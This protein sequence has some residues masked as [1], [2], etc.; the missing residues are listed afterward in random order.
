MRIKA[1]IKTGPRDIK[2]NGKTKI[3]F[4]IKVKGKPPVLLGTDKEVLPDHWDVAA[5]LPNRK[6]PNQKLLR[7]WIN[8]EIEKIE[9]LILELENAGKVPTAE[10]VKQRYLVS[11]LTYVVT[12]AEHRLKLESHT[13]SPKSLE[14][15]KRS[16]KN[17]K[18]Y[19]PRLKFSELT[20]DFL[21]E[22]YYYLKNVKNHSVNSIAHDLRSLRKFTNAALEAGVTNHYPFRG[23]KI[24]TKEAA[25]EFNSPEEVEALEALFTSGSLPEPLQKTLGF[26]LFACFT[27]VPGDDLRKKEERLEFTLDAVRYE[28]GKTQRKGKLLVIP[29]IERARPLVS[30]IQTNKLK[31]SKSRVNND[32][33]DIMK[34]AGIDKNITFHC[35]RN[36]FYVIARRAGI[37][38]GAIQD[39]LGHSLPSTTN[40]Y[41][42]IENEYI[43]E[44][45]EKLNKKTG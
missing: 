34:R 43:R 39:I 5:G 4:S 18:E 19:V 28:R 13:L 38:E 37:A 21:E 2:A 36:T 12:F 16:I 26:Y 17:L 15:Y 1:L 41:K 22:Y 32:L 24:Q 31:V 10:L 40:H 14:D 35:A 23:Y 42:K 9:S 8:Q 44:N 45:L 33:R 7:T 30:F 27:G 29:I 6:A 25:K 3:Y 20:K 11:D